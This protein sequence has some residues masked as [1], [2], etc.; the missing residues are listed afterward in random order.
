MLCYTSTPLIH[1]LQLPPYYRLAL[2]PYTLFLYV[3]IYTSMVKAIEAL[4]T[5][6]LV[7][8]SFIYGN[9]PYCRL[10][11]LPYT[12]FLSIP[13]CISTVKSAVAL[14]SQTLVQLSFVYGASK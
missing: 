6:T 12:I 9:S 3:P 14:C 7:L 1:L 10:A 8:R 2:I 13:N 11:L 5:Q 4:G